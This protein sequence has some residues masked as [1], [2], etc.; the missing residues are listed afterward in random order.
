MATVYN[1]HV[2]QDTL[3]IV[4]PPFW[5]FARRAERLTPAV[6]RRATPDVLEVPTAIGAVGSSAM[7]GAARVSRAALAHLPH[8]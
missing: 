5:A 8:C 7:L 1:P 6:S 2:W 4:E 3:V